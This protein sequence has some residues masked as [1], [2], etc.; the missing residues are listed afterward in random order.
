MIETNIKKLRDPFVLVENGIY[1]V[2]GT[3][4]NADN[5]W[6]NTTYACYKNTSGRL[7][8]EFIKTEN[9]VYVRPPLADKNLWAP[10]V[11]KYKGDYYMFTTYHSTKTDRRGSTILKSSS[12]EGP[13]VEITDGT[14]TPTEWDCIDSTLYVDPDGQPWMIFV[15]EWTRTDDKIGRMAVAKLSHDLTRLIS[16]PSDIFRADDPKWSGG[17]NVTDGCFMYTTEKGSLLMIWSNFCDDGYC[18]GIARSENGKVD[19]R[20]IHE[21]KLLF[22]RS[23]TGVYDGGHAMRFTDTDGTKYLCLHTPNTPPDEREET[24]TFIRIVEEN[25]TLVCKI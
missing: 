12:P 18:V 9:E 16:E 17:R 13:F 11:H 14:I 25:D 19:G 6:K 4:V 5:D 10:E 7:D 20:W 23:T 21:E 15:H 3:G 24:P 22:S 8:G 1:Y 2:Y